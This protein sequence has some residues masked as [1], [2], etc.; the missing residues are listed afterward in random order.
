MPNQVL[1]RGQT[2]NLGAGIVH[3]NLTV[4]KCDCHRK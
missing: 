2:A 4:I 3:G 1:D